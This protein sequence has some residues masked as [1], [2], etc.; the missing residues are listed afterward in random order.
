M[1]FRK[2]RVRGGWSRQVMHSMVGVATKL[3]RSTSASALLWI[4]RAKVKSRE[5]G[6]MIIMPSG[7]SGRHTTRFSSSVALLLESSRWLLVGVTQKW[8]WATACRGATALQK[9]A[10]V[11]RP[12]DLACCARPGNGTRMGPSQGVASTPSPATRRRLLFGR[13]RGGHCRWLCFPCARGHGS[14][15]TALKAACAAA[16]PS[17]K[18]RRARPLRGQWRILQRPPRPAFPSEKAS[19]RA[20]RLMQ[21]RLFFLACLIENHNPR[22]RHRALDARLSLPCGPER[23]RH[24]PASVSANFSERADCLE[25]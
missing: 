20:R 7:L 24:V 12:L 19:L 2:K 11:L 14:K 13:S 15:R 23:A 21:V 5:P 16:A 1:T 17:Q 3:R 8:R 25:A 18:A 10:T 6:S 4:G 9:V 22:W